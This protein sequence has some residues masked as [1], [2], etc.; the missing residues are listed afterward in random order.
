M[1]SDFDA[2]IH[3][4]LKQGEGNDYGAP[5]EMFEHFKWCPDVL[6][7]DVEHTTSEDA[8]H[9]TI[10]A[11]LSC[12]HRPDIYGFEYSDYYF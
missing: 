1:T 12:K 2:T 5:V 11:N 10:T 6:V 4:L 7:T 9:Y 3:A 8:M